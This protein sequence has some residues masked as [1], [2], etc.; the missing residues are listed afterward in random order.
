MHRT[1]SIDSSG[2]QKS[3]EEEL[4]LE[5]IVKI[6]EDVEP[7]DYESKLKEAGIYDFRVILKHINMM[8]KRKEAMEAPV[9]SMMIMMVMH[10]DDDDDD[11]SIE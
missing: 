3:S 2:S 7:K 10:N 9:V 5:E 1:S 6:L 11:D 4:T 8:K